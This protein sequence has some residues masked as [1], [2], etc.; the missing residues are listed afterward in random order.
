MFFFIKIEPA[1]Y[2]LSKGW[3]VFF[4]LKL[5]FSF[6]N[7]SAKDCPPREAIVEGSLLLFYHPGDKMQVSDFNK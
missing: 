4:V 1:L 6:K 5:L 7:S 2:L 3:V